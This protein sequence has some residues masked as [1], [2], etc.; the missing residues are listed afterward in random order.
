[1]ILLSQMVGLE[2]ILYAVMK[3]LILFIFSDVYKKF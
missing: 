3:F 2:P 1:M